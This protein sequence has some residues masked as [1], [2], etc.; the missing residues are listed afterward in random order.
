MHMDKETTKNTRMNIWGQL[1]DANLNKIQSRT[2]RM[3]SQGRFFGV[4][5]HHISHTSRES[6]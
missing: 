4:Q 2:L 5:V 3:K 1:S 6:Y